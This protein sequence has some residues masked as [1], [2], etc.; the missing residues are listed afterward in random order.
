MSKSFSFYL[1]ARIEFGPGVVRRA[2]A[3]V[4]EL[5]GSKALRVFLVTDPGVAAAG[6]SERVTVSL[7]EAGFDCFLFDGVQANPRDVDC[8]AGGRE[9]EHYGADLIVAVGGGSVI[10]SA[11][12]IALLQTNEGSLAGYVSGAP[13]PNRPRPVVAVPT[14]AGTGSEV[15]RSAV[16]TDSR[17]KI[18][19]TVKDIS[20]APALA[21][22]DPETTTNLPPGLTASTGMDALVHAVEAYT[23]RR[24]N[25][26]SDLYALAAAR[27]ISGA[28]V[29]AVEDGANSALRHDLML[30]SLMAGIAFSHAD[31]GA[32]HCMA[33]AVGG[34]YDI[35]HGAANSMFLPA[36]TAFNASFDPPRHAALAEACGLPA[37]GC[38]E[39]ERS[40]L[41][42]ENFKKLAREI[43]IP[44]FSSFAVVDPADF[45]FLAR[46]AALNGST[47]SNCR[48]ITEDDYLNLFE[49]AYRQ[50]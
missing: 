24:H 14:T 6:I 47:P 21:L 34:Y 5:G 33:E 10:D 3:L 29:G 11:K 13:L 9:A 44:L 16:I 8:E 18:K 12:A 15:T 45:P 27:L 2:G 30:G 20:L 48:P 38:S 28:L 23:C 26:F 41:L 4:R 17:E 35:A 36:V 7:Q 43:N 37:G 1:P 19:F 32:V 49:A 50:E 42:A 25:P 46:S 40:A 39:A 31:V 22:V